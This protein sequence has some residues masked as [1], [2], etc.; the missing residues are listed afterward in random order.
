[1]RTI[2]VVVIGAQVAFLAAS[3]LFLSLRRWR[4]RYERQTLQRERR[5]LTEGIAGALE[6]PPKT[7]RFTKAVATVR[8]DTL[9]LVLYDFSGRVGGDAWE[10]LVDTVRSAPGPNRDLRRHVTSRLWWR[11]LL[12]A[13]ALSIIG[14]PDDLFLA[15]A[16]VADSHPAVKLASISIARRIRDG[17]LLADVLNQAIVSRRVVR[18]YMFDTLVT[19]RREL[20][21]ILERR[22]TVPKSVFELRDLIRLAGTLATPELLRP[23]L[24]LASHEDP[25]VRGGVARALGSFPHPE[26]RT[27]LLQLI[28]DEA[29][30]VRTRAAT[31]LGAIRAEEA[32]G[33]LRGALRD[34]NWWVRLRAALAL[35]QL[36]PEGLSE[37]EAGAKDDDRFAREMARYT[38]GL[39]EAAVADYLT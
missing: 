11:R 35:R 24:D 20:A 32:T 9:V 31:S 38:L 33:L 18:G 19:A 36:G 37:L 12:G 1:M 4:D 27:A 34:H 16:L 30:Q 39:T 26:S 5:A 23:V 2:L 10:R 14:G 28:R 22:L 7:E 21:P 15:K 25:E 13:R 17:R 8:F 29:W 3:F 6:S